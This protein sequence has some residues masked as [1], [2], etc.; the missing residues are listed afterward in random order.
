MKATLRV[1]VVMMIMAF[2]FS[3][4]K[5]N[6]VFGQKA[7][8]KNCRLEL[9]VKDKNGKNVKPVMSI[10]QDKVNEDLKYA[11]Y[12]LMVTSELN[13]DPLQVYN[14]YHNLWKIEESFRITK[15]YLD[16]RPVYVQKKETIY[17]HFL[18]CYLS[19][20]LLRMMEIKCFDNKINSYDL[21]S[22]IRDFR[23]VDKGD[24][25]YI[26]ISKD[27]ASN[28]KIKKATGLTNLDALFLTKKE[29]S[30]LFKNCMLID[31]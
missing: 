13:M 2:L 26:N 5:P 4:L 14:T 23:I 1:S 21:I 8:F 16:A 29:V 18:I 25:T 28:E 22:F 24:D 27:Q 20:F 19:L 30:N 3:S 15:S 31:V 7:T 12:N 11:G 17:G 9:N 6:V 10:D